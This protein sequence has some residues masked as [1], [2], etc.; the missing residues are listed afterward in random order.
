MA[1]IEEPS[2]TTPGCRWASPTRWVTSSAKWKSIRH[3][4]TLYTDGINES[5]DSGGALLHY[6][7][8]SRS[9]QKAL[10]P[11]SSWLVLPSLKTAASFSAK[12][13]RLRYVLVCFGRLKG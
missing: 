9:R 10:A 13:L 4:F 6:R 8:A 12:P 1:T 3:T 5:I 7:P 11:T 2:E